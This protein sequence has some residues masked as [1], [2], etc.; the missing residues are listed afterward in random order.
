VGTSARHPALPTDPSSLPALPA[1]F[2]AT[3]DP[4]LRQLGEVLS[5]GARGAIEDQARLLLAWNRHVNLTALRTVEQV[6]RDHVG[7][8]LAALPLLRRLAAGRPVDLLDLGSGAGYP[9]L[10]LAVGLPCR[11][12]LLL[13]SIGKKARFLA[14]VVAAAEARWSGRTASLPE[15]GTAPGPR[16]EVRQARAEALAAEAATADPGWSV[17]TARAVASLDRLLELALPLLGEEGHLVAWKRDDGSGALGREIHASRAALAA[18]DARLVGVEAVRLAG[19]EDHRLV[20]VRR[21]RHSPR[22]RQRRRSP[23]LP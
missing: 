12:V 4:L 5:D 14:A 23:L 13:E 6:A 11:R 7:D 9:G 2:A 15:R 1:A 20:V 21:H 8:S 3:L 16:I 22:S 19:L 18:A 17:V 10:P